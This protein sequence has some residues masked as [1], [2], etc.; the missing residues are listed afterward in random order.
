M[1]N[2]FARNLTFTMLLT[3][4][5]L[6]VQAAPTSSPLPLV[7]IENLAPIPATTPK[8]QEGLSA[9][10]WVQGSA[11]A[12]IAARQAYHLATRQLDVALRDKKWSAAI[13]QVAPFKKLPPAIILDLDETVLD[14]SFYQARLVRDDALY[15]NEGW[16]SWV[17]QADAG[18]IE[19]AVPFL[20][21][22]D[23]KGVQIFYVSNRGLAEELATV[24]NLK[25][26]GCPIQG[27]QD[28][29]LMSGEKS[30]WTSDKTTRRQFVAQ[31]YRILLLVGDDLNDFV[32][33][34]PRTLQ[35][36][37]DLV[38]KYDSYW[39]ERWILLS[40][41]LYG[42]WEG[43]IYGYRNDLSREEMLRLKY[44]A[45]QYREPVTPAPT[46]NSSTAT[47]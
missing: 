35:E 7:P 41:P 20:K 37:N 39:G 3:S 25:R 14:N 33:A 15:S 17:A 45:L 42:S 32:T 29:V 30:D 27:P 26:L 6:S 1:I 18:A 8:S 34:K 24:E 10:A 38:N 21:Y 16:A 43:A 40:N 23:R 11:E 2:I 44:G 47:R 5:S 19:G 31:K 13:E 46:P 4:T 22:A 36:R 12:K 28:H 9:T